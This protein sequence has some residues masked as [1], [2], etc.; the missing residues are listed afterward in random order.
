MNKANILTTIEKELRTILRDKKTLITLLLFPLFIPLFIFIYGEIYNSQNN[1]KYNIGIN[2][3]LNSIEKDILDNL[4]VKVKEYNSKKDMKKAYDSS[5]I[6]AYIDKKYNNYKI[7]SNEK[8]TKSLTA[9]D[10]LKTYLDT[11]NKIIT[12]NK[13]ASYG[14]SLN[15]ISNNINYEIISIEKTNYM[16]SITLNLVISYVIM[17]IALTVS[18]VATS[19]TATEKENGTLETLLTFPITSGEL[20]TGKYLATVIAGFISALISLIIAIL[21][22]FIAGNK[23]EI[24]KNALP[25]S[26]NIILTAIIIILAA[27]LFISGIAIIL[28]SFA[29]SFKEAQSQT[30]LLTLITVIPMLFSLLGLNSKKYFYFIPIINYTEILTNI[31]ENNINLSSI[32]IVFL[33]TIIYV[34]III[35]YISKNY[36]SEKVLFS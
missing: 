17:S 27:S 7:Y 21:S 20:I 33:S 15:D 36:K 6:V 14:I 4:N 8:D 35:Y 34:I 22:F 26:P 32:L 29:K 5:K 3:K 19:T 10:Y 18:S 24:F 28:T 1:V 9:S 12:S 31:F 23:Y 16:V 2:Y 25:V 11:Y 30:Q 13:L